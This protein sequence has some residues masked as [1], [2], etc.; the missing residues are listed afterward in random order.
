M[1]GA[2]SVLPEAEL[3]GREGKGLAPTRQFHA[4]TRVTERNEWEELNW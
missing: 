2:A 3:K 4:P 1:R